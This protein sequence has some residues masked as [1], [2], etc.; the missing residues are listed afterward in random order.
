MRVLGRLALGAFLIGLGATGLALNTSPDFQQ[1]PELLAQGL[2][3]YLV[4]QDVV[5]QHETES[6]SAIHLPRTEQENIFQQSVGSRND[7]VKIRLFWKLS[8]V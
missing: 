7:P 4:P 3:P 2:K 5:Q 6:H 8:G 1:S